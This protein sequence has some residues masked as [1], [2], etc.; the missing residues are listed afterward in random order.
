[1]YILQIDD[2]TKTRLDELKTRLN[3]NVTDKSLINQ[4]I[5][6]YNYQL[7]LIEV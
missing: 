1:M 2:E 3:S 5:N 6:V 4:L 7:D